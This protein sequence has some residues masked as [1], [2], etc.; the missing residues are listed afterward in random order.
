M[1]GLRSE[2]WFRKNSNQAVLR[3]L[4]HVPVFVRSNTTRPNRKEE[5]T[6]GAKEYKPFIVGESLVGGE[7]VAL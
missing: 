3:D 7:E 6:K 2:R 4:P 5:A 1:R